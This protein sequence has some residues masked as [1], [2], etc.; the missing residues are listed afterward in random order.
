M[1]KYGLPQYYEILCI[2][3]YMNTKNISYVKHSEAHIQLSHLM[4][5]GE[6]INS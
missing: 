1:D 5:L 2:S 6:R 3:Y 4:R